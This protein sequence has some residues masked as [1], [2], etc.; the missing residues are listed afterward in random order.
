LT[1]N[2]NFGFLLTDNDDAISSLVSSFCFSLGLPGIS[3]LFHTVKI[4]VMEF[5]CSLD[6]KDTIDDN[7]HNHSRTL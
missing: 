7:W 3:E 2:P 6:N 4:Q 1:L 5:A